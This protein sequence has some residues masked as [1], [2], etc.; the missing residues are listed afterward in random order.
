MGWVCLWSGKVGF[1]V[2][3][4]G[5]VL[6]I[7]LV[8]AGSGAHLSERCSDRDRKFWPQAGDGFSAGQKQEN[9][10]LLHRGILA[11]PQHKDWT[12]QDLVFTHTVATWER[13]KYSGLMID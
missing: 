12:T 7:S 6:E 8:Q 9:H 4:S 13:M 5:G 10:L 2:P 3:L 1:T 11:G